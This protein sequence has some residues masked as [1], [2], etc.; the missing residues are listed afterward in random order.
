MKLL[1][2]LALHRPELR[3]WALYD[4]ANSAMITV[5]V[6]AVFPIFFAQYAA[7]DL[8]RAAV[9]ARFS[10]A[11]A[12][13]LAAIALLA[14]IL[15]ALADRARCKKA[16]LA[17]FLALGAGSVAAMVLIERGE[18]LF[19]ALLFALANV[20]ASGSFVFY[21]SLLPHVARGD[22]LDR[23]STT[24]Y[25]LGYLGGGL[26]LA[27]SLAW[28]ERP[29]WFG[30][31]G[32]G[33]LSTRLAFLAVALWWVGFS[34][35]LFRRVREPAGVG[36]PS[37]SLPALARET[38][39][40]ARRTLR[41]LLRL[42]Q[43]AL[44]LLAFLIYNDGISTIIRMA[45]LYGERIG[46]GRGDLIAAVVMVQFA[47]IPFTLLFGGLAARAGAKRAVLW[48]VAVYVLIGLLALFMRQAWQFY[49]LAFLVAVVQGGAQALSRSLFA[50]LIPRQRSA[51]F[52]G[53]FAVLD[54][55]AGVAGPTLFMAAIAWGGSIRAGI[56]PV[57]GLFVV[58]GLLLS[59]VD[60]DAGR[61][62]ARAA[63]RELEG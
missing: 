29:E 34:L 53:L 4:W 58:G 31:S 60:V 10:G 13:S 35:P 17:V 9:T 6:T 36:P 22:E 28:I 5:V 40:G 50:S 20:G 59:R 62:A 25:A 8:E 54:R 49:L 26:V 42:R 52:F 43:A 11:T 56:L 39:A 21:D 47:G 61:A 23:L 12:I 63:E 57:I 51:E 46:L 27:A 45:T 37:V 15:G 55:F 1:E 18:W 48:A 14:P 7:V 33:P 44:M 16:L 38:M 2:R 19:A 24:G 32:E 30:L 3:A 41:D